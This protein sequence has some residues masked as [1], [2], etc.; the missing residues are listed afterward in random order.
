MNEIV[1]IA[2]QR[3]DARRRQVAF[4]Q[5][6]VGNGGRA[7]G[8]GGLFE[9]DAFAGLDGVERRAGLHRQPAFDGL[10]TGKDE[11]QI[12][13]HEDGNVNHAC[14]Y[15]TIRESDRDVRRD[16]H[17]QRLRCGFLGVLKKKTDYDR[18]P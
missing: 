14:E 7:I 4:K 13:S 2:P 8:A 5:N 15:I 1:V 12:L 11:L 3:A 9:V 17:L 10:L 18:L 6:L 16:P